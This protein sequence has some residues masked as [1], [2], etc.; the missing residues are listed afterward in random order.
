MKTPERISALR[1]ARLTLRVRDAKIA[2]MKAH[3]ESL[4]SQKGVEV[5]SELSQELQVVV[6]E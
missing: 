1:N 6:A 5:D 4:L 2:K 3:F